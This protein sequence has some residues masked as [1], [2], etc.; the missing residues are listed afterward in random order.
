MRD[1]TLCVDHA[2][3]G[4]SPAGFHF[5]NVLLFGVAVT[6]LGSLYRVIFSA[7]S[8]ERLARNARWFS[9]LV[10]MVF[11]MHPLQVEPVAFITA[12][13]AL[14]AL[15]FMLATLLSYARFVETNKRGWYGL[16]VILRCVRTLFESDCCPGCF[17][18]C[19]P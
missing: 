3:F 18:G 1:L 7:S 19:D 11:A 6:L 4:E 10:V 17:V 15:V 8:H 5:Q 2:L 9:L 16:S 12:R 13:N 14:L